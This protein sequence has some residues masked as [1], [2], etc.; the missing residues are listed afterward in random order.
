M[1]L[2]ALR[3]MERVLYIIYLLALGL[4]VQLMMLYTCTALIL[5]ALIASKTL[6]L[7][8]GV[9]Y[10]GGQHQWG[11]QSFTGLPDRIEAKYIPT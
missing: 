6:M 1:P 9:N 10:I 7:L 8:C 11:S 2:Y 3:S 5:Y 4:E